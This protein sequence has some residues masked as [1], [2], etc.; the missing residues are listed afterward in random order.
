MW[1]L[2]WGATKGRRGLGTVD[3]G[4][5]DAPDVVGHVGAGHVLRQARDEAAVD[6]GGSY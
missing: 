4:S 2:G 6:R 3:E 1:G 5:R